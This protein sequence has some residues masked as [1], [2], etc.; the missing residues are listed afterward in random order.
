MPALPPEL[1][2]R[3]AALDATIAECE[4]NIEHCNGVIERT[5]SSS[6]T[7]G[8]SGTRSRRRWRR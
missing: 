7:R 5:R 3:I 4:A 2:E 8:R 6:G 1:A